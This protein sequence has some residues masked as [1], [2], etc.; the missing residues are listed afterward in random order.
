MATALDGEA[1]KARK[2]VYFTT[3]ADLV[4]TSH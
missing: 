2:S 3:L 4:A 1:V